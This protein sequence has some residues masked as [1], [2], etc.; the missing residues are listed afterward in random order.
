MSSTKNVQSDDRSAAAETTRWTSGE[1]A[2]AFAVALVVLVMV[3]IPIAR[4]NDGNVSRFGWQM[5]SHA[6]PLPRFAV[7]GE[8]GESFDIEIADHVSI[9]RADLPLDAALPP[10]LCENV[11]GAQ[12]IEVRDAQ[13]NVVVISC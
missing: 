2:R 10:H 5:F 11:E 1:R 3:G 9:I 7:V 8:N 12:A 13:D 6:N 4:F